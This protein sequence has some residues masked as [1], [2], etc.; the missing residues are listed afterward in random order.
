MRRHGLAVG[1]ERL[2][3]PVVVDL[4]QVPVAIEDVDVDVAPALDVDRIAAIRQ[5]SLLDE[6]LEGRVADVDPLHDGLRAQHGTGGEHGDECRSDRGS[7]ESAHGR[8]L[9]SKAGAGHWRTVALVARIVRRVVKWGRAGSHASEVAPLRSL[10]AGPPGSA[11]YSS[12]G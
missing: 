7:G 12:G 4:D 8:S 2:E 1:G 6:G 10:A 3:H 5:E 11:R 9:P